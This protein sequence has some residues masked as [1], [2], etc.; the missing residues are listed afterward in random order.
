MK[1]DITDQDLLD[2]GF[3][4]PK[5]SKSINFVYRVFEGYVSIKKMFNKF[6]LVLE[7]DGS[8]MP[9]HYITRKVEL[10][11]LI[12]LLHERKQGEVVK[13]KHR[14]LLLSLEESPEIGDWVLSEGGGIVRVVTGLT[15]EESDR[16]II[17]SNPQLEGT[18]N[19]N[20]SSETGRV[21]YYLRRDL[22]I[23]ETKHT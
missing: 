13:T 16:K 11:T 17:A 5:D 18:Y 19:Y 23:V 12:R 1:V 8:R 22:L 15:L 20:T 10:D 4:T 14:S 7:I 3:K 2:L 6:P 21:D 9:L